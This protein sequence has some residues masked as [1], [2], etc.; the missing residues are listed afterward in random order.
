MTVDSATMLI[1]SPPCPRCGSKEK[2]PVTAEGLSRWL[3]SGEQVY[4]AEA[5]PHFDPD[6]VERL[7]TGYCSSCWDADFADA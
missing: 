2:L 3:D 5:F 6:Q 4:I 7:L 1:D